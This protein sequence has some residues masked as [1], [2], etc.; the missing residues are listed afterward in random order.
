M[1]VGMATARR[2]AGTELGGYLRARREQLQPSD[3]GLP[4][5]GRRRTPGLRREEVA[6]LAGVSLDDLVRLE[7]GRDTHPSPEVIVALARALRLTEAE[8]L[9]LAKLAA[10]GAS[11]SLC[12]EAPD[13]RLRVPDTVLALLERMDAMPAFVLGAF[14]D[15][16]AST[17][18]WRTLVAPLGILDAE[19][20]NLARY[21]L[22]DERSRTAFADWD[23]LA[24]AQV[25][26]LREASVCWP[27]DPVLGSLL[28]E[29]SHEPTFAVRWA[30]HPVGD[31]RR[32]QLTLRAAGQ[33]LHLAVEVL[34]LP[35]D[36]QQLV[37]WLPVD[38]ATAAALD[39]AAPGRLRVV[40]R[41]SAR[42]A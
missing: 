27:D 20:A 23:V 25:G 10:Q 6:T 39:P 34:L 32:S 4:P 8:R 5:T 22:S 29:L 38:A 26:R 41:T 7:Q 1:L 13:P 14:T 40:P 18:A 24:D 3:V 9:H 12:P 33:E 35:D 16:L 42:T 21:V 30:R 31:Q 37:T 15:V 19:P 17:S 36:G 28:E 11:P 2:E